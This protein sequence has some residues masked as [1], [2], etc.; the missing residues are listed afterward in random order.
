LFFGIA[1][2]RQEF[3]FQQPIKIGDSGF[4]FPY[5]IQE[6]SSFPSVARQSI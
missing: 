1:Q 4:A 3:S 5:R 2:Q 6:K